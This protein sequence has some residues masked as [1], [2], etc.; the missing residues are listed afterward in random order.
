[1]LAEVDVDWVDMPDYDPACGE[2]P[3]WGPNPEEV[4][5]CGVDVATTFK[6]AWAGMADKWPAAYKLLEVFQIKDTEQIPM[7]AAIDVNGEDL[8]EVT[9]AW[10]SANKSTWKPWVDSARN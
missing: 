10:V 2:D 9:S 8:D 4:N 7:M 1:V 5:D 3:S 6:V